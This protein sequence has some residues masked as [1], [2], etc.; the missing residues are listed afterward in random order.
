MLRVVIPAYNCCAFIGK[1]LASVLAQR[2][3]DFRCYILDDLST[4][5]T[6]VNAARCVRGDS[7]F[8][9]IQNRKKFW[10]VGNYNQIM[11]RQDV[12]DEDPV[13]T[14]D[15]DDWL[16]NDP[17]IF[18]RYIARY[19]N[20]DTW[21]TWGNSIMDP[22]LKGWITGSKPMADVTKIRQVDWWIGPPR[23]WRTFLWRAIKP[24][25]L[26]WRGDWYIPAS[27]DRACFCPMLEMS[28]N[29]HS[30]FVD[31]INYIYNTVNPISDFRIHQTWQKET[32]SY[33]NSLT[34][35]HLLLRG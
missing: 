5:A 32:A 22:P 29:S 9:L 8:E 17:Q 28:G 19:S 15:G 2:D 33:V 3:A 23:T 1:C 14:L 20:P 6:F 4:D 30:V 31:E 24:I 34:P 12:D 7:R 21:L 16:P 18:A 10:Q 25:D 26:R 35:Y 27:G 11:S 13:F